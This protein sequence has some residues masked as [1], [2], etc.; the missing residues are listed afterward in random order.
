MQTL[1]QDLRYA[2][3]Q[4][5]KTP[6]L[7]IAA[8]AVLALG[9]GANT[10]IFS[11]VNAALLRPLPFGRPGQLV[12]LWHTPPPK[13]FP[14]RKIFT[15]APA[16]FLDWKQ[17]GQAFENMAIYCFTE[18]TRTGHDEPESVNAARVSAD[19]FPTLQVQ[20]LIGRVFRADE[21]QLGRERE[22][23]LSYPYWKSRFGGDP[24]IAGKT[25][26]LNNQVY[27]IVGVMRPSFRLPGWAKMWTPMAFT[28]KERVV[29][30][31]HHYLAVARLKDGVNIQQA[32]AELDAIS[33]RLEEQYP[34]DDRGW[35]AVA[36]PLQED[37][38]SE[39]KPTLLVLFGAVGFVL[40]IACAN[41]A[42]LFL[43]KVISRR[44]E[45]A[46]RAALGASRARLLQQ[47]LCE[48]VLLS[49]IGAVLGAGLAT[50]G[51]DLI[52]K[53]L[54]SSLPA[55][56]QVTLDW[57]VLAFTLLI[58]LLTGL[59]A[60]V[61]PGWRLANTNVQEALKQAAGRGASDAGGGRTRNALVAVEV[62]LSLMLL[63]GAGLMMRTLW[64]LH[65]VDAGFDAKNV[66]TLRL[67]VDPAKYASAATEISATED[68]LG[69][70][71]ALP[72]VTAAAAVDDLP[73][74]GGSTQ[75][76]AIA[77]RVSQALADQPEVAVRVVTPGYL[78]AM[79]IPLKRGRNFNEADTS[80]SEPVAVI[81]ESMAKRFW[82]D[83]HP[84]GQHLTLS[85]YPGISREIVGVVGD[86]KLDALNDTETA[87]LYYPASQLTTP[88]SQDWQSFG[89]A[90]VVRT[91]PDAASMGQT[92]V[93]AIHQVDPTVPVDEVQT[94]EAI[95]SDSLT[96]QR[97]T[98]MLLMAFGG[99]AVLLA[100][101]GIY[102]VLAYSVRQRFREIGIRFTLGA[103]MPDV[104]RMVII[105]GIKPA[106]IGVFFGVVGALALGR[107]LANLVY[108]VST[109]DLPTLLLVSMLLL[110]VALVASVVPAY[111]AARVDPIQILRDE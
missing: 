109:R 3:R 44:K 12:R 19:F 97:F 110:M 104:L 11:V 60:G 98:M 83:Q 63:V 2:V 42:N 54:G 52:T 88:P 100:G 68:I 62:G 91:S 23:I 13:S 51:I 18:F 24:N 17:Q 38:V 34:A 58:A 50:Y 89:F 16:N 32:Q 27:T 33:K 22:V 94:M 45:I 102:G 73:L 61:L 37:V 21:D 101:V 71:R 6:G 92:I 25:V 66:V 4:L 81:S 29:R 8:I 15:I 55:S 64:A 10:A 65:K 77:G 67:T 43:A 41:V 105:D 106:L 30:G 53:F 79:R 93:N 14:G 103:Q 86:V 20:P 78:P 49:L 84:M 69:H 111:R 47:T 40:L 36:L 48:T 26:T 70:V 59:F 1:L 35:G 96:Q 108:G 95:V 85:F 31:E 87:A 46:V 80:T 56:A 72:G 39:V 5:W 90:F 107:V 57:E 9:I 28:P 82:P 76:I 7:S 99:L 74:S 75:P